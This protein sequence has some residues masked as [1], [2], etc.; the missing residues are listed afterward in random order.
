[1]VG[2]KTAEKVNTCGKMLFP[3]GGLPGPL[4][5][6]CPAPAPAR[7]PGHLRRTDPNRPGPAAFRHLPTCGSCRLSD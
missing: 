6:P 1:M 2:T 3:F 5:G 4:G 7:S